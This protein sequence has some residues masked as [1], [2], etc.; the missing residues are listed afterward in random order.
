M[1][2]HAL[3]FKFLFQNGTNVFFFSVLWY[4]FQVFPDMLASA[5]RGR[6]R[7][8][9]SRLTQIGAPSFQLV[10]SGFPPTLHA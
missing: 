10:S 3:V 8:R 6:Q 7:K 2:A 1:V 9:L 5:K 4:H